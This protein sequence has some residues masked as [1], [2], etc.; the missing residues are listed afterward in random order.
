MVEYEIIILND[1]MI[2]RI[3]LGRLEYLLEMYKQGMT[4][5]QEI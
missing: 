4:T 1:S 2:L 5:P 3:C